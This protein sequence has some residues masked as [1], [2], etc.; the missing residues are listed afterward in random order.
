MASIVELAADIVSSQ[1][2]LIPMTA[3]KS[4]KTT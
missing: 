3:K 2:L 1:A 4:N